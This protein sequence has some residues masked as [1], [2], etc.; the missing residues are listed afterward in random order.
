MKLIVYLLVYALVLLPVPAMA[1]DT[2]YPDA[3]TDGVVVAKAEAQ[4]LLGTVTHSELN[5]ILENER[6]IAD[7]K[8]MAAV[9]EEREDSRLALFIVGTI[10]LGAAHFMAKNGGRDGRDGIDGQDG[11]DGQDGKDGQDGGC[12]R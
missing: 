11:Q 1:L 7:Q 3:L 6:M 5:L 2:S 10:L 9:Q 8:R 12:R 4:G